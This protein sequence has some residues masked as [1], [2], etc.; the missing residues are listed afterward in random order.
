MPLNA[1]LAK[2]NRHSATSLRRTC[3]LWH[4][5]LEEERL[6]I[7]VVAAG[8]FVGVFAEVEVAWVYSRPSGH[9]VE[10]SLLSINPKSP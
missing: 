6:A 8:V 5:D 3:V 4:L 9:L 10:A 1:I 7:E 2:L